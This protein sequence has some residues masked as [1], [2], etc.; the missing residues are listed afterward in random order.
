MLDVGVLILSVN[1]GAVKN[2]SSDTE[3]VLLSRPRILSPPLP[4]VGG[5][6][7]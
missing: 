3:I 6:D 5:G 7:I 4:T 2:V 1:D